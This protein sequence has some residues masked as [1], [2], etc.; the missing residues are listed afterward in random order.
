MAPFS[1]L[2]SLSWAERVKPLPISSSPYGNIS[3][4]CLQR[5]RLPNAN[6]RRARNSGTNWPCR[7]SRGAPSFHRPFSPNTSLLPA[8]PSQNQ[9]HFNWISC[10]LGPGFCVG[11][12]NCI[13]CWWKEYWH[14]SRPWIRDSLEARMQHFLSWI[15]NLD[16]HDI[17]RGNK[18][19]RKSGFWLECFRRLAAMIFLGLTD[20]KLLIIIN[21]TKII[22][23]I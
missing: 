21:R 3:G 13:V 11:R 12:I 16:V 6:R 22:N 10:A 7:H 5:L 20:W 2:M 8:S 9:H 17:K 14:H 1:T 15:N 19:R 18:R 23:I 4:H